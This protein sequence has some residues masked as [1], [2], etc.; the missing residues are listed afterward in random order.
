[1]SEIC[2][3]ETVEEGMRVRSV[4][5]CEEQRMREGDRLNQQQRKRAAHLT[6]AVEEVRESQ[7]L[8]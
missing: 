1:M 4:G 7:P 5:E 6:E 3:R 8:V 2:Q